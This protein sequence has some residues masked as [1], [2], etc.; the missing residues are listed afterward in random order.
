MLAARAGLRG[1]AEI[2]LE[3]V[4][5]AEAGLGGGSSDAAAALR[6]LEGLWG[7]PVTE[8]ELL[9]V[10]AEVGSDV[11]ALMAGTAVMARGRGERIEPVPMGDALRWLIQPFSF[12]VRTGD[13]YAWWDEDGAVT[14]PDP[15]PL[16]AALRRSPDGVDPAVVGPLLHNDLEPP[17]LRRHPAIAAARE[18]LLES[19]A[20]GVVLCGSGASLAA[21]LPTT[22][23]W[24]DEQVAVTLE[25]V[26]GRKALPVTG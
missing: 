7:H 10:G 5:P 24:P 3:K 2:A 14:G 26:A 15:G 13:A 8:E 18:V 20:A 22:M 1:F 6:V 4:V 16:I 11:P 9:A 21:L 23:T 12:G 25:A 17:V 19:G